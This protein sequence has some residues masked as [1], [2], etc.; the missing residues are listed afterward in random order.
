LEDQR[1]T[2]Q[3]GV[4]E[5]K[6]CQQAAD[7]LSGIKI[8]RDVMRPRK[9][10]RPLL[11]GQPI[12][13]MCLR[14]LIRFFR[15][16]TRTA[17][18]LVSPFTWMIL[19]GLPLSKLFPS[20]NFFGGLPFFAFVVPG[21]LG[22]GLLFSGTN[23]GVTVLWDKEFG[24][25]KEVM[26][27]PV[28]RTSLMIGRSLG[29]MSIAMFQGL[30]SLSI[31]LFFGIWFGFHIVSAT[32]LL[33]ALGFMVVTFLTFVGFGLTLGAL[34]EGTEGFM[35]LVA[36]IEMPLFFLSGSMFPINLIKGIPVLYQIQ[37]FN[38]LTYG[39]DGIRGS[40][41][42]VYLI[43]PFVDFAV[44]AGCALFFLFLGTYAFTKMEV[45]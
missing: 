31:A 26:V 16:K 30:I 13:S 5:K 44:I 10:R 21:I 20:G 43:S 1:N 4:K 11:E 32:G 22:M 15:M 42:G 17:S 36:M 25:L 24:F 2:G 18:A 37:F 38:P 23:S 35:A 34:I 39:I 40:L 27:A 28:R 19:F 6:Y 7:K 45:G 14:E 8:R 41:T 29:A 9:K 33:L 3:S 12:Y